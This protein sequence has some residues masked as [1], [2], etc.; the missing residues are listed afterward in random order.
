[1]RRL[2]ALTCALLL[3]ACHAIHPMAHLVTGPT[4]SMAT[5]KTRTLRLLPPTSLQKRMLL[6]AGSS[7]N[8][9]YTR[10]DVHHLDVTISRLG[11]ND[12][13]YVETPIATKTLLQ[14][15]LDNIVTFQHLKAGLLYRIRC[16]AYRAPGSSDADVISTR[17]SGSYVDI[18][19]TAND[20]NPGMGQL[21]VQLASHPAYLLT[22]VDTTFMDPTFT[23]GPTALCTDT[24]NNLYVA[25]G[26][27]PAKIDKVAPDGT[28]TTIAG[29]ATGGHLDGPAL[30]AGFTNIRGMVLDGTD[31]YVADDN[32]IRRVDLAGGN[33]NTLAGQPAAGDANGDPTLSSFSAPAGLAVKTVAGTRTLFIC[34]SNNHQ[35][36]TLTVA[37]PACSPASDCQVA[38]D[39]GPPPAFRLLDATQ[40]SQ[41]NL[42]TLYA[43]AVN[44]DGDFVVGERSRGDIYLLRGPNQ[45]TLL[46]GNPTASDGDDTSGHPQSVSALAY[47]SLGNLYIGDSNN[48]RRFDVL[49]HLTTLVARDN[50]S[51][52]T[53]GADFQ[54]F[55]LNTL[56]V[57]PD[58]TIYC[59]V[60]GQPDLYKLK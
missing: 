18:D 49:G 36:R 1:M 19:L 50:R 41:A 59:S 24:S 6:A 57:T 10:A 34:D 45:T 26:N 47:D 28:H 2:T 55:G 7:A 3:T 13:T 37:D 54:P 58:G 21:Q 44:P 60:N 40:K 8:G 38:V 33:V 15:D 22:T 56:A 4:A 17:D 16:T 29:S 53:P 51:N 46:S 9:Y 23:A 30:S 12:E 25:W 31:L 39:Y 42:G 52:G 35:L 14:K 5:T 32:Y 43:I 20:D 11:N 27:N 48:V